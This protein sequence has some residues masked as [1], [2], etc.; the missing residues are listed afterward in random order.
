MASQVDGLRGNNQKL[1]TLTGTPLN[2]LW[3]SFLRRPGPSGF[4]STSTAEQVAA[5]WDGKGK[6]ALVT[7]ASSGMGLEALRALAG[8][9]CEVIAPVRNVPKMENWLVEIR[10]QYPD[11][12]VHIMHCDMASLASTRAFTT[13]FK[14]LGKPLNIVVANGGIMANAYLLSDDGLEGQFAINYLAHFLMINELL[15]VMMT[16]AAQPGAPEGRVVVVGSLGH[17]FAGVDDLLDLER[18]NSRKR[19]GR[20]LNYGNSKMCAMLMASE[21]SRRLVG[22][23]IKVAS[24]HPGLVI[25]TGVGRTWFKPWMKTLVTPFTSPFSKSRQQGAA[26]HVYL[27]TAPNIVNGGYYADCNLAPS[28]RH[29]QDEELAKRLWSFSEE[30][31][32]RHNK[33][34]K[35][36]L[37]APA[38]LASAR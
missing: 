13:A 23:N 35:R 30:L 32:Q 25:E 38:L 21:L 17:L 34:E 12:K 31:L 15:P 22:T 16:T 18:I 33:M 26:T 11:C 29:V 4:T 28:S 5:G 8:R 7:G 19:Y 37:Q 9:G 24:L 2:G 36:S 27:A 20:W 1:E 6:V 3:Q 10:K 14:E